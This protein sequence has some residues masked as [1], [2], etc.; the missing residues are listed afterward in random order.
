VKKYG[1]LIEYLREKDERILVTSL[2]F[3]GRNKVLYMTRS[4]YAR[5]RALSRVDSTRCREACKAG[6]K[7][8]VAA[9][10]TQGCPWDEECTQ[11][12]AFG[13]HL[14]LLQWL[15]QQ[16]C[17]WNH[18]TTQAA[19][20]GKRNDVLHWALQV[21]VSVY[22]LMHMLFLFVCMHAYM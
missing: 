22:F 9:L 2:A 15:V 8:L 11:K 19:I 6:D 7:D 1:A 3:P 17:P 21:H 20:Q 12:A 16:G 14:E 4:D 13:G 5:P 10:R 18:R